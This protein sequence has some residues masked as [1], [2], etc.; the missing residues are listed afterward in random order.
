TASTLTTLVVF[1]P[2]I[3]VRGMAGVMFKQ[4]SI[5]ISFS[6]LCS[7]VAAVTLVPMLCV[8]LIRGTPG[9]AA[10]KGLRGMAFRACGWFLT[11]LDDSY[12]R[13]LRAALGHRFL[14]VLAA[15]ALLGASLAM[16]K[17]IGVEFMPTTDESDVRVNVEMEPGTR[18]ALFDEKLRRVEAL[19]RDAVPEMRNMVARIGGSPWRA[20]GVNTA[21][22]RIAI[23]PQSQRSRSSEEIAQALRKKLANMPGLTIRTRAGEGL[24]VLRRITMSGDKIEVEVRGH[25]LETSDRLAQQ[26]K[27][28]VEAVAGVTDAK[29]SRDLGSPEEF[30]MIDR[31]KAADMRL[32]VS[33]I[34]NM[35]QTILSGTEASFYRE[36]GDEF[37]IRVKLKDPERMAVRDILDLTITNAVGEPVVLR[38]VVNVQPRTGPMLIERKDQERIVLVAANY[39]GRDLGAI[40][41]DIRQGLHT[42]PVPR[43]FTIGFSADYEEQQ[44]AF[45]ELLLSFVLAVILVYMVMACQY[46]SLRDPFVVMFSVPL[47]GIGVIVTLVLTDTTFNVQSFIGCIMLGGIVVNNAILLVDYTNLLRRRD[48]MPL[49]EA[50]VE[51]GRRRL[52]PILMTTTTTLL[53]LLPLALGLGE[54]GEAQAPMARVVIGGLTSSTLITLVLVPSVYYIFER[55]LGQRQ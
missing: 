2:L 11:R 8:K 37:A 34:A 26:V 35:L 12:G 16:V 51:A 48:G 6:L 42:I 23:K 30:V 39:S 52:R 41:A 10:R 14:V 36:G 55:G 5:V 13:L 47:A 17:L 7:L 31:Q 28:V 50:V 1:L 27:G 21:E 29:I 40:L 54:G 49:F 53:G 15:L 9:D 25:D 38:N 22:L 33:Q 20:G 44:K 3:F 4:L 24:T 32:T 18:L 46:E 43:D 19:V 45:K